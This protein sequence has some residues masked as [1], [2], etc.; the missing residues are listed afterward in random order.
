MSKSK[1]L[2]PFWDSQITHNSTHESCSPI[3]INPT[4]SFPIDEITSP[5]GSI[6]LLYEN[7]IANADVSVYARVLRKRVPHG[8]TTERIACGMQYP[9]DV[10]VNAS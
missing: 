7:N 10:P 5:N 6:P 8:Y 2:V 1:W 9:K 4:R 3:F